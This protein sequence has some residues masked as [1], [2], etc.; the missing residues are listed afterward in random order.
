[1]FVLKVHHKV[2]VTK[3]YMSYDMSKYI[4]NTFGDRKTAVAIRN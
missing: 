4:N 2:I 3:I 1:M